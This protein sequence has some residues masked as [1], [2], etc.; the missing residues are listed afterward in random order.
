MAKFCSN[1]HQMEDSWEI[2]PYCPKTGFIP[3]PQDQVATR[4]APDPA[5]S[6]RPTAMPPPSEPVKASTR[7]VPS[8]GVSERPAVVGCLIGLSGRDQGE[9]FWIRDGVNKLGR[10]IQCH[11]VL[12]DDSVS[13]DHA[14]IRHHD[15]GFYLK[16]NDSTNGTF[17]NQS[18]APLMEKYELKDHDTIRFG[19]AV[20]TFRCL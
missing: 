9:G 8:V 2:C 20:Y 6:Q 15:G 1:G 11:V 16:D 14:T 10:N 5:I 19:N 4:I 18:N 17:V 12:N 13:D 7:F 3:G